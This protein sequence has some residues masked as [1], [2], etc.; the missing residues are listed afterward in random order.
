VTDPAYHTVWA[1][2]QAVPRTYPPITIAFY[3]NGNTG[4]PDHQAIVANPQGTSP[5]VVYTLVSQPVGVTRT[6]YDFL[7]W[8]SDCG[9]NFEDIDPF[10]FISPRV[11]RARWEGDTES[12]AMWFV[13]NGGNPA[14]QVVTVQV[15]EGV[16]FATLQAY[17]RVVTPL[18]PNRYEFLGWST[19]QDGSSGI[20]PPGTVWTDESPRIVYAQWDPDGDDPRTEVPMNFRGNT[21]NAADD[22]AV[23]VFVTQGMTFGTLDTNPVVVRPEHPSG[24]RFLGWS[25]DQA[26][27][28]PI[29]GAN[30][31]WSNIA[32]NNSYRTVWAQWGPG[33]DIFPEY[34]EVAFHGNGGSPARQPILA[35]LTATSTFMT[36][37]VE[38]PYTPT[39]YGYTFLGWFTAPVDGEEL[40]A[41]RPL[42]FHGQ[43]E[44]WAQ[45]E[46]NS[47]PMWFVGN[48]GAPENQVVTVLIC[49]DDTS[50]FGNLTTNPRVV[51][52]RHPDG[53]LFLGWSASEDNSTGIIAPTTTWTE[54]SPRI[55]YAQWDPDEEDPRHPVPMVFVSNNLTTDVQEVEA[56]VILGTSTFGNLDTNPVV[57]RPDHV[58]GLRFLGWSFT[59]NGSTG[60]IADD[61]SW[62]NALAPLLH[63]QYRRVYAQWGP[64]PEVYP[65]YIAIGFYGNTGLVGGNER[66]VILADLHDEAVFFGSL[67]EPVG[68][69]TH[70]LNLDFLN[71]GT[72]PTGG[73]P[74]VAGDP[75][76]YDGPRVFYAQWERFFLEFRFDGD[77]NS[78]VVADPSATA[79]LRIPVTPGVPIDWEAS[80]VHEYIYDFGDRLSTGT[81]GPSL[82][83]PGTLVQGWALWGWFDNVA[84]D[85]GEANRGFDTRRRPMVG[86]TGWDLSDETTF[87]FS[88]A[89]FV[90]YGN[91]TVIPF[92]A[93]FSL[94]GD[95]GDNDVV[96]SADVLLINQWIFDGTLQNPHFNNPINLR[97]A[98][99][100]VPENRIVTSADVLRIN[101]YLFDRTLEIRHFFAVLGQQ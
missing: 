64:G 15:G 101:Q 94:W 44:F 59:R 37:L 79:Y 33:P 69:L 18:H 62:D 27:G 60:I 87:V 85:Y 2:W 70:P 90:T 14:E 13:G 84:L 35:E 92:T 5:N 89:D 96:D 61:H 24:Y 46:S 1:Q 41:G 23:M 19:T 100:T 58:L 82:S 73:T 50:T 54:T 74:L 39:R 55:V 32:F 26:P 98:N 88:E 86:T 53:Y 11:F 57:V 77:N 6:N 47:I 20:I 3:G 49:A 17:P 38:Q 31:N 68:A 83:D 9:L 28:S 81:P 75:I 43:R 66:Q 78:T 97:A 91:G 72:T 51:T 34:V 65:N 67:Q 25:R 22:Q 36:Y 99:V 29:I 93:I 80:V 40:V 7:G 56:Y 10:T 95:A 52:P 45:W 16:T 4:G 30:T 12:M 48:G 42:T 71:W 63:P 21:G 8:Y 76:T